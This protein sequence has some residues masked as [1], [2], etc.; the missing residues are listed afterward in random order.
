MSKTVKIEVPRVELV[1]M[2]P[3]DGEG[4]FII[5]ENGSLTGRATYSPEVGFTFLSQAEINESHSKGYNNAPWERLRVGYRSVNDFLHDIGIV[6]AIGKML[7]D[8]PESEQERWERANPREDQD[9]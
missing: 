2:H 7:K 9:T 6:L 8:S 3:D 5:F 1:S 4:E